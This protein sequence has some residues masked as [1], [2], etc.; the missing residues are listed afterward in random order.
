MLDTGIDIPEVVNLVFARPVKSQVKFWQMIGRGTRL[1]PNLFGPGRD[2]T[3]F[4]IFDHYGNFRY[5]AESYQEPENL[6]GKALLQTLFEERLALFQ[7]ALKQNHAEAFNT[8]LAL[9]QAD[10][11]D[12]PES[13]I[14][15][16][17]HLRSVH[18]LQ[19]S[20]L[21][22]QASAATLKLLQTDIAPLMA[23]RVLR[24]KDAI[25]FD[26]LLAQTQQHWLQQSSSFADSKAAIFQAISQ[27]P[28]NLNVVRN[29]QALID[30]IRSA[31][32][33]QNIDIAKL[34]YIRLELRSLMQYRNRSTGSGG[35]YATPTTR[36][37]DSSLNEQA[38]PY[39]L[40]GSELALYKSRLKKIL[41]DKLAQSPALQKVHNG[42]PY[43]PKK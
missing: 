41:H 23:F 39:L 33:W 4:Y 7:V 1:R 38:A 32:F 21:L 14:A 19:Q 31:E 2:K 27:L 35:A 28:V 9:L 13:S 12:L 36:T 26:K 25:A 37:Q 43:P 42:E 16:K 15:V 8:A 24:D 11:A 18:Q 10:I 5:F 34:E 20:D 29:K 6:G 22:Q 17:K 3:Q 30:R 40:E